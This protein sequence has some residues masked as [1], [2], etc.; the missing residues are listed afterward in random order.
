MATNSK[1]YMKKWR[2][3]HPGYFKAKQKEYY[4]SI[5]KKRKEKWHDNE[6]VKQKDTLSH[7]INKSKRWTKEDK[8]RLLYLYRQG[9]TAYEIAKELGRSIYSVRSQIYYAKSSF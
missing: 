9:Y 7:A 6:K 4:H 5:S 1:E 2:E 3:S 8:A